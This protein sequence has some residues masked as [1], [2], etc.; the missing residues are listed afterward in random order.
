M[1]KIIEDTELMPFGKYKGKEMAEVPA[2]YLM[3]FRDN[4]PVSSGNKP[5]HDYIDENIDVLIKEQKEQ[6]L[7][8]RKNQKL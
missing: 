7:N 8:R 3:W 2:S 6:I 5:I 4:V 1:K